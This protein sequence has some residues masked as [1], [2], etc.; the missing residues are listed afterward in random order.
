MTGR[1]RAL[2]DQRRAAVLACM[3]VRRPFVPGTLPR[4]SARALSLLSCRLLV[5]CA[6]AGRAMAPGQPMVLRAGE[7]VSLPDA[8]ALR[9]IGVSAD[10]RCRPDVRCI[11]AGDADVAL[12]HTARGGASRW[13]T[14]ST[15]APATEVG[16]WRLRLLSLEFGPSPSATLQVDRGAP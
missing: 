3:I 12:V 14:I 15:D 2:R 6:S 4:R 5:A 16:G 1:G 13:I 11:R 10:S 8:T 7:S 9:H